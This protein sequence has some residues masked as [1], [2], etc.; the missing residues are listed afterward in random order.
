MIARIQL[1]RLFREREVLLLSG[2]NPEVPWYLQPRSRD[3]STWRISETFGVTKLLRE[4][5]NS[6]E[7]INNN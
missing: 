2:S 7:Q 4:A 5:Q 6:L 3:Q 1:R